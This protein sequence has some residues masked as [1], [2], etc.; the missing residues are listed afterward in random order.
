MGQKWW[1][2]SP[3][4]LAAPWQAGIPLGLAGQHMEKGEWRPSPSRTRLAWGPRH[5]RA[6]GP[7][8]GAPPL[9]LATTYIRWGA[10]KEEVL[11]ALAAGLPYALAAPTS[12]LLSSS[13]TAWRS[14]ARGRTPPS[15]PPH[16]RAAEI[17]LATSSLLAGSRRRSLHR[18]VRVDT[19]E[20]LLMRRFIGL[21]CEDPHLLTTRQV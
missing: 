6:A 11:E 18:A 13:C 21:E 19:A 9:S 15:T 8:W 10:A 14:P 12:L 17:H 2:S 4:G 16:H 5:P 20:T 7:R 1:C 3:T